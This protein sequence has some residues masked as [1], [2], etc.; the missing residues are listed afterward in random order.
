MNKTMEREVNKQV[1]LYAV[2]RKMFCDT[3]GQILDVRDSVL[4]TGT[5]SGQTV[6]NLC[7]KGTVWD[8]GK[9][10]V[11]AVAE[12]NGVTLEVI[13]GRDL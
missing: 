1:L 9:A 8:D 7:I 11:E 3:T 4:I 6:V 10:D 5:K 13:D 12:Q 2:Q